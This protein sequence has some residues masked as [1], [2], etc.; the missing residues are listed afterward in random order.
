[1]ICKECIKK[2]KSPILSEDG[3]GVMCDFEALE[4]RI[5]ELEKQ[6]SDAL[7]VMR[8]YDNGCEGSWI[9]GI[10]FDKYPELRGK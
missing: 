5:E 3:M 1:M 9:A 8:D 7:E 6:L 10:F 2:H 4:S